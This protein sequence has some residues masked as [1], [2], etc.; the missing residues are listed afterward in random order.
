MK[1]YYFQK[2][3]GLLQFLL[4]KFVWCFIKC[5]FLSI[6]VALNFLSASLIE[7]IIFIKNLEFLLYNLQHKLIDICTRHIL[8]KLTLRSW[9]ISFTW[10]ACEFN[11]RI[12]SRS[13]FRNAFVFYAKIYFCLIPRS[14]TDCPSDEN[15]KRSILGAFYGFLLGILSVRH[16]WLVL[17]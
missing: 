6:L 3:Q 16:T 13:F 4:F 15:N 17:L 14:C 1:I 2:L 8:H 11:Q 10:R 9:P 7:I 5:F 12:N